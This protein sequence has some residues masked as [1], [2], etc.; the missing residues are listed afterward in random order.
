MFIVP[1][2]CPATSSHA[3]MSPGMYMWF[4][5]DECIPQCERIV[6]VTRFY[7]PHHMGSHMPSLE[8]LS[9]FLEGGCFNAKGLTLFGSQFGL[10]VRR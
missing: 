4:Y 10:A 2:K 9:P 8:D 7:Y 6:C 1:R 3:C 5:I